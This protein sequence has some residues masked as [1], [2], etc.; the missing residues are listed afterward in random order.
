MTDTTTSAVIVTVKKAIAA[1]IEREICLG[2][3]DEEKVIDQLEEMGF[4]IVRKTY[5]DDLYDQASRYR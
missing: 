2:P 3:G 5:L 4:R 1:I